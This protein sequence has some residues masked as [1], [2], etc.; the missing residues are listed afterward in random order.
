M[1]SL[2]EFVSVLTGKQSH[3]VAVDLPGDQEDRRFPSDNRYSGAHRKRH[4]VSA[5][6]ASP[7]SVVAIVSATHSRAGHDDG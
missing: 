1:Q 3:V 2:S 4:V 5:E 6:S 7:G